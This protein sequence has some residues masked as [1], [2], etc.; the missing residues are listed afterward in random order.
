MPLISKGLLLKPALPEIQKSG[1]QSGLTFHR[2]LAIVPKNP[3]AEQ[4]A[5][6]VSVAQ[7]ASGI[8]TIIPQKIMQISKELILSLVQWVSSIKTHP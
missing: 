6:D 7:N 3:S 5:K 8:V 1:Y 2:V 4:T